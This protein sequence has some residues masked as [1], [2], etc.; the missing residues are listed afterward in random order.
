MKGDAGV[1]TATNLVVL[2]LGVVATIIFYLRITERPVPLIDGDRA[3]F[4][5]LLVIGMGMC[6]LGGIGPATSNYG[7]AHPLTIT[8]AVIGVLALLLDRQSAGRN[9][10]T[11]DYGR[12]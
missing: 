7:W 9:R 4:L 8:G 2:V 5:V 12:S 10:D 1:L 11:R 3:I 6:T